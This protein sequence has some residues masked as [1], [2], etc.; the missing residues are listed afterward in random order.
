LFSLLGSLD[1]VV[2]VSLSYFCGDV[3]NELRARNLP[4]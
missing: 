2:E 4:V 3:H 1:E